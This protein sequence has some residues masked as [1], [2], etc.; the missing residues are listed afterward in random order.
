M[1][2]LAPPKAHRKKKSG[3]KA[4]K[5]DAHSKKK[6][7]L[8][9]KKDNPRAFGVANVGRTK[10]EQQRNM[11]RSQKKEVVP[12]TDRTADD[13][14]PPVFVVVMGPAGVGKTTLIRSLVK[15]Y[16]GQNLNDSKGPI[17]VI[18]GR[19]RR[20]TLF[21]C[22]S[23][24]IC[25][26]T[27][28]A[29]VADL[30]LL[31]VDA[32]YG[33][34]METFE[35][36]NQLQLH[37]FPKVV[38]VL[39]HLDHFKANKQLQNT[40]KAL[41]HRFW[42]EIY[43]GA[44]LFDLSGVVHG[45][46]PKNEVKRL[47]LYVS[48][49]KF[50]P[51]VWRNTHPYVVVDRVEDITGTQA[52][53]ENDKR[54][55]C[56]YGYV[57][58][59]NLKQNMRVHL[60]GAGDFDI[61]SLTAL[62]DPCPMEI[63]L[64]GGEKKNLKAKDTKLFAPMANVGRVQMD[65]DGLFINIKNVH[66][67]KPEHL[68]IGE[69][70]NH[71][72]FQLAGPGK[73]LRNLQDASLGVDKQLQ[74]VELS[75]FAGTKAVKSRQRGDG[76]QEQEQEQEQEEEDEH[77]EYDDD[78]GDDGYDYDGASIDDEE[79][80][81]EEDYDGE[82]GDG[83][84]EG[85]QG[86]LGSDDEEI[87]GGDDDDDDDDDNDDD[88][89]EDEDEDDDDNDDDDDD[90]DSEDAE[91]D[92]DEEEDED[93]EGAGN[94][95][96][97]LNSSFAWKDG[98]KAKASASFKARSA[99]D[100]SGADLMEQV[101][102]FNWAL[103]GG[104]LEQASASSSSQRRSAG[105]GKNAADEEDDDDD[106]DDGELF[107]VK[108]AKSDSMKKYEE[109]NR[110]DS[111][112]SAASLGSS[113]SGIG[114]ADD[115]A[116]LFERIRSKFVTSKDSWNKRR[117]HGGSAASSS[118]SSAAIGGGAGEGEG[119]DEDEVY[120]DFE[121]MQTGETFGTARAAGSDDDS[122]G[123]GDGDGDGDD[124]D[125]ESADSDEV[126]AANE[127]IDAQLRDQNALKKAKSKA[128]F[129]ESYDKKKKG[130]GEDEEEEELEDGE[131]VAAQRRAMEELRSRNR[132]EFGEDGEQARLQLEGFRQ[133]IYVK[134][135]LRRVPVEFATSFSPHN[136][137]IV[138]GLLPHESALGFVRARVKRHRWHKRVLKS[139]DPLIFSIGW[140]RFQSMPVYTMEDANDRLR[141][142][143][144]TPEHMH[145]VCSFYGPLV[146]PNTGIL[147][148]QTTS[149]KTTNFRISLTGTAL[150]LQASTGVVKKLKLVGHPT[151]VFKNTAFIEGMFTSALEVSKF[152][153]AKIKTVSGIRGSIKRALK[154]GK[155]GS[156][157]AAFEDKPL[158]SD[159]VICRLWV[160]VEIKKLYNPVHT[161]LDKNWQGVR[162]VA[163]IRREEQI[164]QTVNKDSLYKPIERQPRVFNKLNIPKKLQATLP[165]ASKPKQQESVN[166]K[167]YLARRAVMMEPEERKERAAVQMLQT[168]SKDKRA[169]KHTANLERKQ[170]S[171][172]AAAKKAEIFSADAKLEKKRKYT[173]QGKEEARKKEKV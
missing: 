146:P 44:K 156:F 167:S 133:G 119:E 98:M 112:R 122:E 163:Q 136:P 100:S 149:S 57:R 109:D 116:A 69:D 38:G 89:D 52:S 105:Q 32:S 60:I 62:E 126:E 95:S 53:A 10:K 28:L 11:D 138:G 103:P 141:Y 131:Y 153:G 99:N 16:T 6:R 20:L 47:S 85:G 30:V 154:D 172:K 54:D 124:S 107:V 3:V 121:D 158:M 81:E 162:T 173:S 35:F 42:T 83:E 49:V 125:A 106:D 18:C 118:S 104:L 78:D 96:S 150:E 21:E 144:Y 127:A 102:G 169:K 166:R 164:A 170:K 34:E 24:D 46:Y 161:L 91:V 70:G 79:D 7:G 94:P 26:M 13:A 139:N 9:N 108:N 147:A 152:I 137:V 82:E 135:V 23:D 59:T 157:R 61:Y 130:G 29:K 12:L 111:C 168:I 97:A 92:E 171:D 8:S 40:K 114:G 143:K 73:L 63:Q 39:T 25:A 148:F 41:K 84:R 151:K 45:K 155:P 36:L 31:M 165:F 43:K 51:L 140:R 101:Y 76:E 77:D 5:K 120:G 159:I 117:G 33:F 88:D 15:I 64:R 22:P 72:E 17:T 86:D 75:L 67:T 123:D 134:L 110:L 1:E 74:D 2:A 65:N 50:R 90:N 128:K 93:E 113:S 14:P 71:R 27:D 4:S 19:K 145:C 66:Y 56:L 87:E 48:R 160:P 68:Q 142:L 55:V 132:A 129:D 80:Q 58:G 37:G 115:S